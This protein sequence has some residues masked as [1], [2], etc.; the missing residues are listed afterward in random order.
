METLNTSNEDIGTKF[1]QLYTKPIDL[2]GIE[3]ICA[4][5]IRIGYKASKTT[6]N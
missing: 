6:I 3:K 1:W 2:G 5:A 4:R